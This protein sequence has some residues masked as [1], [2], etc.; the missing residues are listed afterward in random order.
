[1]ERGRPASVFTDDVADTH[2]ALQQIAESESE[3]AR[4]VTL[5]WQRVPALGNELG[6]LVNA[7]AKA[8]LE[9]YPSLYGLMQTTR[10]RW[11]ESDLETAAHEITRRIP[12][13][14]GTA[15]RQILAACHRGQAPNIKKLSNSEQVHQLALAI[16]PDRLMILIAVH[17][18]EAGGVSLR[19]LAQGAE[20]LAAN[21]RARVV[22][23]LPTALSNER[24]LDHVTYTACLFSSPVDTAA[25][26]RLPFPPE[27]PP[28]PKQSSSTDAV[29]SVSPVL[30]RPHPGSEAEQL[31]CDHICRDS[32]LAA[33]FRFNWPVKT[34]Y[35]TRPIVDLLWE[36]GRLVVEIDGA[37]HCALGQFI[38]DRRRD[39]EL[40]MSGYRVI[41][42]TRFKVLE[43]PDQVLNDLRDAV[44]Y[45]GA[46]ENQA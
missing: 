43:S 46:P 7:L 20:W 5:S 8:T 26:A 41:R 37:E 21:T 30:G 29:V 25:P 10:E 14:L 13:V 12:A 28:K 40:F 27:T 4:V 17:D 24:E 11:E 9:L 36:A 19:A 6:L 15:C 34:R 3:P 22:L 33:L 39:F 16:E 23:V 42:F 1:M 44:R 2:N 31:L 45:L 35:D 38:R 18:A 32:A